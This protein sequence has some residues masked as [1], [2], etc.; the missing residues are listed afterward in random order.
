MIT[1]VK[2]YTIKSIKNKLIFLYSLNVADIM[3]TLLLLSTSFFMEANTLMVGVTQSP[4]IS[5]ILKV[6]L[7]AI[8]LVYIFFRMQNAT[9]EQLKKSNFLIMGIIALYTLINISHLVWLA[10]LPMFLFNQSFFL[11]LLIFL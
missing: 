4:T 5:F 7:P 1:F 10:I 9:V 6:V 3:F 11:I 8:L 2:D